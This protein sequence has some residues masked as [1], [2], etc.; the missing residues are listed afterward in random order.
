MYLYK[1]RVPNNS[2]LGG[3]NAGD[4]DGTP[5]VLSSPAAKVTNSAIRYD[6]CLSEFCVL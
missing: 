3:D 6:N 2:T 5:S 1:R 4:S